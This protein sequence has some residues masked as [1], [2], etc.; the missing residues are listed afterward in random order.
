MCFLEEGTNIPSFD[1][2]RNL[3]QVISDTLRSIGRDPVIVKRAGVETDLKERQISRKK[4]LCTLRIFFFI[5]FSPVA[6]A[7]TEHE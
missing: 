2:A 5:P 3:L 6:L 7:Q 4:D 1:S